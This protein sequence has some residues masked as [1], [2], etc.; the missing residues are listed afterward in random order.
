MAENSVDKRDSI[1]QG[2][3]DEFCENGFLAASMDRISKRAGASKRTVYRYFESKEVLFQTLMLRQWRV[4][5]DNLKVSYQPGMDIRE[6]LI[7]MGRAQARL[8][9]SPEV[10]NANKML[11]TEIL[12][13]PELVR[14]IQNEV[15][16]TASFEQLFKEA[17]A[18]GVLTIS[19]PRQAAEEFISLL[20]GKAFW[21]FMLGAP[22]VSPDEMD[23]MIDQSVDMMMN[24]YGT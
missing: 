11:M 12:R 6:Q 5:A 20:K 18:D 21:P 15:D 10:M 8:Y 24:Q 2:A 17:A 14:E 16:Y 19:N 13:D 9:T 22:L 4:I 3:F 23:A 7:E 1:L